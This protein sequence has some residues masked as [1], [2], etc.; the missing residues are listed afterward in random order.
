MIHR[1]LHAFASLA[2]ALVSAGACKD[3]DA[4]AETAADS[5]AAPASALSLPVVGETVRQGDLVLTVPTTAQVRADAVATLRSETV[6]TVD[7]VLIV[8]GQRVARAKDGLRGQAGPRRR[9]P[10]EVHDRLVTAAVTPCGG[11]E[12][13]APHDR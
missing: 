9:L 13:L 6:G 7:K 4:S 8:P 3:K 5:T 11:W 12:D 1:S 10:R 2:L